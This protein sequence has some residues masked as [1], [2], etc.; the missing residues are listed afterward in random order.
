MR[1]PNIKAVASASDKTVE[2]TW[3]SGKIDRVDLTELI[4]ELAALAEMED[5][6]TFSAVGVGEDG[7]SLIWPNGAEIGT[8]TLWRLA[9]EQRGCDADSRVRCLACA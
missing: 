6:T 3:A 5:A 9:R 2:I 7:W 4:K 1:E 8:D